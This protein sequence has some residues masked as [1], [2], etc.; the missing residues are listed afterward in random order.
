MPPA[1]DPRRVLL[2]L[3]AWIGMAGT[4]KKPSRFAA[5]GGLPTGVVEAPGF[6]S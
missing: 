5:E 2:I 4:A 6:G 3:R 1:I